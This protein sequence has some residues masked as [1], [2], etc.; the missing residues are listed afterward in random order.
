MGLKKLASRW[1]RC[2]KCP[3]H[4]TRS[5]V[6]FGERYGEGIG[7]RVLVVGEAPGAIEDEEGRPFAG[8]GGK[9]L[10][11]I[12]LKPAEVDNAFL[13]STVCCK[14][15]RNRKPTADEVNACWPR[16]EEAI[17]AYA[18]QLV[19]AAGGVTEWAL[20]SAAVDVPCVKVHSPGFV[21]REGWPNRGAKE[22]AKKQ[23]DKIAA[24]LVN[25]SLEE[26]GESIEEDVVLAGEFRFEGNHI[27]DFMVGAETAKLVGNVPRKPPRR[28][29]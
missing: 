25:I 16:L 18:P 29:K 12:Y 9:L 1:K 20:A 15:A 21:L 6:V 17:A 22:L 26:P 10:R 3:L 24:A 14:P 7:P 8:A 28:R 19:V 11:E 2:K 4:L 23:S 13:T 27:G 5:K